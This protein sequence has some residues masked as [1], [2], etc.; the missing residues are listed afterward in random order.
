[1]PISFRPLARL[2][3]R[4]LHPSPDVDLS[5]VKTFFPA[6]AKNEGSQ[7]VLVTVNHYHAPDFQSWWFAI[8]ISAILPR[9]VHWVVTAGWTNSGWLTYVTHW[10]FPLGARLLGFTAMPAMPPDPAEVEARAGAV[11]R[12]LDYARHATNPVVGMAPEGQD[13]PGGVLGELPPGAGRFLHLLAR[14]CPMILP[15]GVW[16]ENGIIHM[17]FGGPY[18]LS[19]PP[20]LS[21][22]ERDELAG[23]TVMCRIAECLPVGLR[24]KYVESGV[25]PKHQ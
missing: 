12:V 19:V 23:N 25:Y 24:G 14:Y 6:L 2:L 7:G 13:F 10:L 5:A 4:S 1:M 15:V 11:S 17:K 8:L 22:A 18:T 3:A 21:R 16:K 20:G 9:P